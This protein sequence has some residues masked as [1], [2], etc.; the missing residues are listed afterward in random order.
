LSWRTAPRIE[1]IDTKEYTANREKALSEAWLSSHK[2]AVKC[3]KS[4]PPAAP[5]GSAATSA[6]GTAA[7]VSLPEAAE[8][9]PGRDGRSTWFINSSKTRLAPLPSS[10]SSG[11]L[12]CPSWVAPRVWEALPEAE[13]RRVHERGY[14]QDCGSTFN[15][16]KMRR[17]WW[18]KPVIVRR[19]LQSIA[20][21]RGGD[22]NAWQYSMVVRGGKLDLHVSIPMDTPDGGK[23]EGSS[24][25]VF[26]RP[27]RKHLQDTMLG[28]SW[29]EVQQTYSLWWVA[30]TYPADFPHDG[31]ECKADFDRFFRNL[32][33]LTGAAC[34][35]I[36]KR[37]FQ[38]RGAPH[39]HLVLA[40]PKGISVADARG[41][42]KWIWCTQVGTPSAVERQAAT[43]CEP[44]RNVQR[45]STYCANY[46]AKDDQNEVPKT[47]SRVVRQKTIVRGKARWSEWS[48]G[49][50]YD[51]PFINPGRFWG[52]RR[53]ELLPSC[54]E[55]FV[56]TAGQ[57]EEGEK[58]IREV[59][60]VK[61]LPSY[62]TLTRI[63]L[64]DFDPGGIETIKQ[65]ILA[66]R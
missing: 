50:T 26:S 11:A 62:P 24:I 61:G 48:D 49:M 16:K 51:D 3:V 58:M 41:L 35:A 37:E 64:L 34:P 59:W 38:K 30:L 28:V 1:G 6:A 36:W 54:V 15:I 10:P 18:S 13:R 60:A 57:F 40:M 14:Q 7:R 27:S 17:V 29:A 9:R 47:W 4:P 66:E 25:K 20:Y 22:H 45:L 53:P 63:S 65:K 19:R 2:S 31:R 46:L 52:V 42:I 33:R 21:R 44:V 5:L 43:Q 55:A 32:E 12:P 8:D 39:Y 56:I 23:K